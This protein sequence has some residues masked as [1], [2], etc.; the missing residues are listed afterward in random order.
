MRT[1]KYFSRINGI[2]KTEKIKKKKEKEIILKE[3]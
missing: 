2:S 3:I 1:L